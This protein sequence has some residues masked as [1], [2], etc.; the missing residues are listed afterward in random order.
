MKEQYNQTR[1]G[2]GGY[3]KKKLGILFIFYR[4]FV[5]L[6]NKISVAMIQG[7]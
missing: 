7:E 2:G 4:I 6:F 1:Q 3:V 5:F